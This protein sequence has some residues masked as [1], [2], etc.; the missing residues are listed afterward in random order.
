M[1]Y[2]L[3]IFFSWS[4]GKLFIFYFTISDGVDLVAGPGHVDR[5]RTRGPRG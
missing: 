1:G 3:E 2:S 4:A 5:F